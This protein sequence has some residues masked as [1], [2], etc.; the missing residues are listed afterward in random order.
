[1]EK[2]NSPWEIRPAY[3]GEWQDAMALAWKTFLR[4][5]AA[6]YT[7]E[8]VD[9]FRDFITDST[10]YRMFLAGS[11]ELIVAMEENRMIGMIT[12]RGS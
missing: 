11:Y 9:R 10:L 8:G 7:Q 4:Y 2:R 5:E 3:R 6:D 12:A 1:M